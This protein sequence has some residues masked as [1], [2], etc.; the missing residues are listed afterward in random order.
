VRG[1]A[2]DP[3]LRAKLMAQHEAGVP[4]TVLSDQHGIAR[5]VLSRWW[6]RYQANDLA[7]L[8]PRSRRPHRSPTAWDPAVH[9]AID[10]ARDFG[11]GV[12]RIAHE[13]GVGHG[14]VQ[15]TLERS[16]RNRWPAP[17]R[18]PVRRY[19][20]TRPGELLHLDYKYLPTLTARQEFEYVAID[21]FSREVVARIAGERSTRAATAFL[22]HVLTQLPYRIEAV[23][24]DNDLLF[25][26]RYAFYADRLTRFQQALRSAGITHRL[27][28]PRTPASNG[29]VERMIKTIDDECFRVVQ[30]RS[31][32]AR[33][34]ALRLFVEYYNH[35][36]PH[37]SLGGIRPV[38]RRQGY[39]QVARA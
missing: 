36:R 23:M 27:I 9:E 6:R 4:L 26:M 29:K 38:A 39:Y 31:S 34:G 30:P 19:E 33:I 28:K 2:H 15:R 11:W 22:E 12:G 3:V 21:D 32:R 20:K 18:R 5:P 16:G 25:T 7:G 8:Q 13:L 37:Q 1:V 24:T 10:L 35:A 17:P 14:T